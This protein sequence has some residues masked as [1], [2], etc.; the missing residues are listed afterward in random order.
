MFEDGLL[1]VNGSLASSPVS[2]SSGR[3]RQQQQ[4]NSRRHRHRRQSVGALRRH[5][6]ARQFHRYI[7][8]ERQRVVC[9]WLVLRAGDRQGRTIRQD[10]RHRCG[11][12]LRRHGADP[13]RSGHRLCGE[14]SLSHSDGSQ[15]R[16]REIRRHERRQFRL[17]HAHSRLHGRYGDPHPRPQD[18]SPQI[19]PTRTRPNGSG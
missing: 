13:A 5:G 10:R 12:A 8:R 15:R 17:R 19:R 18:A 7:E 1:V 11:H 9:R 3:A 16:D 2:V 6:G 4:G 14:Q